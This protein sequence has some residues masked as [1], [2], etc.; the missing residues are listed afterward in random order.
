[1]GLIEPLRR[2]IRRIARVLPVLL[3][4]VASLAQAP[5]PAL[6]QG[7]APLAT[8]PGSTAGARPTAGAPITLNFKDADIDSVVGAFGHL[9]NKTFVIDPRVRGKIT[10]ETPRAVSPR[11]AYELL[12]SALRVQGFAIVETGELARVVPEADAKLQSG[13]V[14]VGRNPQAGG[15]SIVT[16]IF[17]LNYESASNMVPVLRPLISPNNTIVAYPNNNSL[18]ITDYAANLQ[19]IARIVATLD[20]PGTGEVE[21]VTMR[22]ALA[23]DVALQVSRMLDDQARTGGA[24]GAVVDAGQ[25][26]AVLADTRLNAILVRA[27]S[28]ARMNLAKSLIDRLDRPSSETGNIRVVYLRNAEA[29]RLVQV[30]RGVLVGE[31]GAG[32]GQ[33]GQG[34][35]GNQPGS[36]GAGGLGNQSTANSPVTGLGG[37]AGG[38]SPATSALSSSAANVTTIAAGGAVI[39]A[40]PATNS[41]I[42]TAPEPVYRNLRA[43]I[44]RLDT[45]RAQVY[46]E[47]LIVEVSADRSMELGVQWQFL[48]QPTG[49]GNAVIGGTN[50][51]GRGTGTNIID[52]TTNIL[53]IGR[54]LNVGV[55]RSAPIIG[56]VNADGTAS[57]GAINLGFLA[58]ALETEAGA[59]ILATPNLVTL[60]NEEARIIIG[61]NVPFITGSFTATGGAG[62]AVNPFQTIERRDVGTTL[63]VRPQVA[64]GGTVRMQIFQEVSSVQ[65]ASLAAGLITNKRAIESNVL[66][67]DGQIVVLGGLIEERTEGGVS[68]VPGLGRIPLLG[69]LFR[70]DNRRRVKTNLLVFLRPVVLRN[71]DSSYGVT[72]DRYDYIRQL[73]GNSNITPHELL[74]ESQFRPPVLSPMPP[75][76][77]APGMAPPSMS[78]GMNDAMPDRWRQVTPP[79]VAPGSGER[80]PGTPESG[81]GAGSPPRSQGGRE[82]GVIQTA[83]NEII[84]PR[85]LASPAPGD[86]SGPPV[87]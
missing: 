64:E 5:G 59:N 65:D 11:V 38:N 34:G 69:N 6:A 67:D 57:I 37:P 73:Q 66:V 71:A 62:G 36:F 52:A 10:L 49:G 13:P 20:T 7:T 77:G 56:G 9:L 1:L 40:D 84:I 14:S 44:D 23:S 51:P 87:N 4:G 31:S 30:L 35:A 46:I 32:G 70:Y 25:R 79:P 76:P 83:P 29:T 43:V 21:V 19:R 86:M 85:Q 41:L 28:V 58:R 82:P 50:L 45:R 8:Q 75:R 68:M 42:I 61:Q 78:P 24:P 48:S 12:Q 74:P 33:Q 27:S 3:L 47:S 16:Q 17:R 72:A 22:H 2:A 63:R 81:P 39:A 15:D 53:G 26:V 80:P 54:G 60:D 18:V 55:V